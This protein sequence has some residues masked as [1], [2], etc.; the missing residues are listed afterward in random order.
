MKHHKL[1]SAYRS[2]TFSKGLTLIELMISLTL[3]LVIIGGVTGIIVSSGQ[4]NRANQGL[5]Q[6]QDGVRLAFELLAR[7]IRQTGGHPCGNDIEVVNILNS[8]QD[9]NTPWAVDWST[10]VR[11]YRPSDTIAGASNRVPDTDAISL[12]IGT[13]SGVYVSS[14][15]DTNQGANFRVAWPSTMTGHGFQPG[16][17]LFACNQLQGTIFQMTGPSGQNPAADL[18]VVNTGNSTTPGNCTKGLGPIIPGNNPNQ[19]CNTNGNHGPYSQNTI[20]ASISSH[21]WYI[22][23]NDRPAEGG[24]SL[25]R[26]RMSNDSGSAAMVAEEIISGVTDMQFRYRA[27][28]SDQFAAAAPGTPWN[29]INAV[30]VTLTLS[31]L[32]PNISTASA[33]NNGRLERSF[34]QIVSLRN[35]SL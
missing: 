1:D 23:D 17:I 7:D 3:G 8:A 21:A 30:E 29:T 32:T 26:I 20:I 11:G 33:V 34:T 4:S 13:S 22:G 31:S 25:Y 15:T 10:P 27:D 19:P 28:G 2:R 12:L 14:Y 18:I 35:R 16:D 5:G 6:I 24:R 9:S